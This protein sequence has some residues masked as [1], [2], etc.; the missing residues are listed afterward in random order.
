M[1]SK[2]RDYQQA[3]QKTY[4][5]KRVNLTLSPSEYRAFSQQAKNQKVTTFIKKLALSALN[6]QA[7]IPKNLDTEL[8]MLHFAI[9]NI[10]NNVNQIAHHSNTVKQLTSA[11]ENNLLLHIKQLEDAVQAYTEGKI[12]GQQDDDH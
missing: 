11:E 10:A 8:K 3:Y 1:T 6:Q 7:L 9:R 12:L 2:R 4:K 5:G